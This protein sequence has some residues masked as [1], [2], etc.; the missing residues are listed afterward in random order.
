ME[1]I[2]IALLLIAV[3]VVSSLFGYMLFR[4]ILPIIG[5]MTGLVIGFSGVQAVF[6]AN[7]W[8]FVAASLTAVFVGLLFAF[9]AH[10]YYTIG[11]MVVAGSLFAGIFAFFGTAIGL[12]EQGFIVFLLSLTGAII[13]GLAVLR[14][15]VQH[16]LIVSL[17]SLFGVAAILL[18]GF[19]LFSDVSVA[20]LHEQGI[21]ATM[22]TTI[23]TSWIWLFVLIGGT[24]FASALQRY[25]LVKAMLEDVLGDNWTIEAREVK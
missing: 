11:V 2:L 8:S 19:L 23:G 13:G 9:V 20:Q 12:S 14:Y 7:V 1:T 22:A 24:V 18:S 3:G 15:G 4:L 16:S 6:G 10:L 17:T 25:L 5:F 21:L